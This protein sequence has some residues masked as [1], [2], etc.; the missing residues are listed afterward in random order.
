VS[1]YDRILRDHVTLVTRAALYATRRHS[2]QTRKGKAA[3]PYA[4]HLAEVAFLLASTAEEPDACLVAAGW[5]HDTLEDTAATRDELDQLFGKHVT[6]IVVEVTD[7]KS[8]PK[9]ER[10]SLQ[11]MNTPKKSV[12]A[13][14][15][16][17]ADKI[18]N[19]DAIATSPPKDWDATRCNE[20]VDWAESVVASCKGL[21]AALDKAFVSAAE[22]ARRAISE[23]GHPTISS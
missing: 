14:L 19:L 16:K 8:L 9:S 10:K 22:A 13:R 17:V 11:V 4:N 18:S 6:D 1:E 12:K 23:R 2:G 7:D 20:Y 5:L 3:E 15:L 21:N